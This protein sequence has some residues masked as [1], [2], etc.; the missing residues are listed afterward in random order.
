MFNT[1]LNLAG[2]NGHLINSQM[3]GD[4]SKQGKQADLEEV[5]RA[6]KA[7][8]DTLRRAAQNADAL[9]LKPEAKDWLLDQFG[10]DKPKTNQPANDKTLGYA[11]DI[12]R[13]QE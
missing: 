1:P 4:M 5:E 6:F 10:S 8:G 9:D 2:Y 3:G 11:R 7:I 12:I 13:Q